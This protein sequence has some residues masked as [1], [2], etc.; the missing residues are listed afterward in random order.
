MPFRKPDPA[1]AEVAWC[2]QLH[3]SRPEECLRHLRASWP[4]SRVVLL[5][6]GDPANLP[7][8][9]AIGREFRATVV[10]G[11]HLMKLDTCHRY[12]ER[13]LQQGIAGP[14]RYFFRIDPDTRI[15]RRFSWLPDLPCAF[16][17][18][19]TLSVAFRD[20]IRHPPNIQ[21]GCVG[22]TRE[23]LEGTLASGVLTHDRCVTHAASGWARTRDCTHVVSRGM[24]LDD[25]L[26]S[27][28]V[29][30]AGFPIF[31]HAEIASFWRDPVPNDTGAFAV[32][33]PH[34]DMEDAAK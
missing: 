25:F 32:T 4:G 10:P 19:E 24:M 33:H 6:D 2:L 28:A 34:K 18:L 26:L 11:E 1:D 30:A 16:G 8:Y 13:L 22:F 29:D 21:G 23:A 17:T 15:W 9:Q 14:E 3:K 5:V 31:P 27:W 7:R 12:V 20:R